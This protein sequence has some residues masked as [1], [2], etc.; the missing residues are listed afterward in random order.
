MIQ[1]NFLPQGEVISVMFLHG[2]DN[3]FDVPRK[4]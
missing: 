3:I 4:L 1:I 2:F